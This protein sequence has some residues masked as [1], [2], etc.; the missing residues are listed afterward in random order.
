MSSPS[1]EH[2]YR[3]QALPM[4][5]KP[6]A[7]MLQRLQCGEIT[8]RYKQFEQTFR[9]RTPYG[10]PADL[11]LT[12]PL[13]TLWRT[14]TRGDTGFAESFV[15]GEWDTGQLA[16]LLELLAVNEPALNQR[17]GE[18]PWKDRLI[19][20]FN[21]NTRR[22]SRRNIARH[23]DLGNDF[24]SLWL[25]ET[26]SYSAAHFESTADTLAEAQLHKYEALLDR[27]DAAPGERL[28]EIGCGWGGLAEVAAKRGFSVDG[29]T[30]SNQQLGYARERMASQGLSDAVN[31]ELRDYR[32][33]NQQYDHAVSIEMFEAVG[34]DYWPVFFESLNRALRPGGRAAM[35]VITINE[36]D[37]DSYRRNED[38]IQLYIFPGGML[39]T[40]TRFH[41]CAARAGF[42]VVDTSLHAQDYADTLA[43]WATAFHAAYDEVRA[44]GFDERF[45]RMWRYYLAYCEAGFRTGKVNLARFT[46]E[47]QAD[48]N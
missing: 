19:H 4:F 26:M 13:A 8:F 17:Y 45:V 37:F 7:K 35:Q 20:R 5:I 9:A 33:L 29:V 32:Q 39:P 12:R 48:L 30:L 44:L 22:G 24:Y 6:A 34:E 10:V 1:L 36:A 28:L 46:L 27:L 18:T 31:L 43:R 40:V 23:Y 47:K 14:L 3:P 2:R 38:F 41:E 16:H 21:G 42:R 25:D 15:Y 11:L